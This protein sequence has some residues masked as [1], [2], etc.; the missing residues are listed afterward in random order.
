MLHTFLNDHT[1][2]QITKLVIKNVAHGDFIILCLVSK[3]VVN[4]M[5]IIL[6]VCDSDAKIRERL[7]TRARSLWQAHRKLTGKQSI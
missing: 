5:H 6:Y 1:F 4:I 3:N 7:S 2:A